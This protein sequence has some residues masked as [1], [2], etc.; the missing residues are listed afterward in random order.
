MSICFYKVNRKGC[1]YVSWNRTLI[2][3][4]HQCK[5]CKKFLKDKKMSKMEV[6]FD[7]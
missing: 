6:K 1:K 5:S 2:V 7:I 4:Y 3:A